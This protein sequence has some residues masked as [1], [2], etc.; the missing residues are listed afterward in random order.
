VN[1][2]TTKLTERDQQTVSECLRAAEQEDFFP[3]WE[4]ET[5]FGMSR[6]Q[7]SVVRNQWPDV[8]FCNPDVGAAVIGALNHLLGYPHGQDARWTRYISVGPDAIKLTL[9]KLLSLGL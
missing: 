5:L 8:D 7:L 4:F 1:I 9:D 3:E 2:F 6:N